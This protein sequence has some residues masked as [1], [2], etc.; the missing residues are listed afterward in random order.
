MLLERRYDGEG[1]KVIARA[2]DA[3]QARLAGEQFQEDPVVVAA[4]AGGNDLEAGNR[5]RRQAARGAL[6]LLLGRGV[7]GW[8]RENWFPEISAFHFL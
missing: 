3:V 4:A 7:H 6:L 1:L 2:P 5:E 8:S